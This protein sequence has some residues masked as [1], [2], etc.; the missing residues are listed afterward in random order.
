MVDRFV[1]AYCALEAYF[2]HFVLQLPL[3][4]REAFFVHFWMVH[5]L[6]LGITALFMAAAVA[7]CTISFVVDVHLGILVHDERGIHL[8]YNPESSS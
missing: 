5:R 4:D 3:F 8:S 2:C 1:Q 6:N 7:A